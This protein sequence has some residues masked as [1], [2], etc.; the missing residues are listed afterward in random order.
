MY[1]NDKKHGQGKLTFA[2]GEACY[3]GMYHEDKMDGFGSFRFG[4]GDLYEVR[5]V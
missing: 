2:G 3:D 1:K 5:S 4:D